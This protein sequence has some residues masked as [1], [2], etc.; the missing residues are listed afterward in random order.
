VFKLTSRETP[1]DFVGILDRNIRVGF[2]RFYDRFVSEF[3]GAGR[4]LQFPDFV[5]S[6][7]SII[8]EATGIELSDTKVPANRPPGWR[9]VDLALTVT[10]LLES[11]SEREE[12]A[13]FLRNRI[14]GDRSRLKGEMDTLLSKLS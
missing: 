1:K 5:S 6:M 14:S 7:T 9:A 3:G 10:P 13:R 8:S 2:E 4:L 12:F 11:D